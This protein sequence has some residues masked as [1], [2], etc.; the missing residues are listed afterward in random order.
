[1]FRAIFICR[2][3]RVAD[4]PA[5]TA[6]RFRSSTVRALQ[7]LLV[8]AAGVVHAQMPVF[9]AAFGCEY[10]GTSGDG[11]LLWEISV[12]NLSETADENFAI[13]QIDLPVALYEGSYP[14]AGWRSG[15]DLLAYENQAPNPADNYTE[16]YA[17]TPGEYVVPSDH[18]DAFFGGHIINISFKTPTNWNRLGWGAIRVHPVGG[19]GV[20][21]YG[22]VPVMA[23]T[24]GTEVQWLWDHGWTNDFDAADQLD[25]DLDGHANWQ[26]YIADADQHRFPNLN[27][28][29]IHC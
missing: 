16:V 19:E 11:S 4:L 17:S 3:G 10:Q 23:T 20:P 27:E 8:L 6:R 28:M 9:E 12:T 14:T 15:W 5:A 2:A 13:D 21:I 24:N 1:M 18:F 26:E 29:R 22:W 25:A 7:L